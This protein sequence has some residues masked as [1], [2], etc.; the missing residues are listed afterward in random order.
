MLV[1]PSLPSPT[2]LAWLLWRWVKPL[3]YDRM[4][5]DQHEHETGPDARHRSLLVIL[6]VVKKD[7]T[8]L[9]DED[10][11]GA[12]NEDAIGTKL[13]KIPDVCTIL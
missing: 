7:G 10:A 11:I 1:H 9:S 3:I 13:I 2:G 4:D 5:W 6:L 12:R 8:S